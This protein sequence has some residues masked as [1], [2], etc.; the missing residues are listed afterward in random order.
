MKKLKLMICAFAIAGLTLASCSSDDDSNVEA[1]IV[2]K[3]N[4]NKTLLSTNGSA[5]Q[6]TNYTSH[7]A[8]CDKDYQEF[9]MGGVFRD[10]VLFKNASSQC[11]EDAENSTWTKNNDVLTIG[12]GA[13]AETFQ[14]IKLTGSELRYK[15]TTTTGGQT[16]TVTQVFT[17]N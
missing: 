10:V 2:G 5:E 6:S 1:T 13:D 8:G 3:W 4:Y 16:F 12:T 17:K 14:V 11:T 9:V 15:S 7:E